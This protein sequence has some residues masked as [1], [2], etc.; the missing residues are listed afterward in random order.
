M[1]FWST[2]IALCN[3]TNKEPMHPIVILDGWLAQQ[4][5]K[6]EI[7][8]LAIRLEVKMIFLDKDLRADILVIL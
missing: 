4:L 1:S 2:K 7:L 8:V 3:Y 6:E 5:I